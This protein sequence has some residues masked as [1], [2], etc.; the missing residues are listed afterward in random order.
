MCA[1][2]NGNVDDVAVDLNTPRPIVAGGTGATTP[3]AALTALGAVAKAGDTMT[4]NL[5]LQSGGPSLT[6]DTSTGNPNSVLA[7]RTGG[8][9]RWQ[10]FTADTDSPS[11]GSDLFFGA[12]NNAGTLLNGYPLTI[13]RGNGQAAFN[14]QIQA[15]GGIN[16]PVVGAGVK[17]A[18][19][20]RG[21]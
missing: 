14:A 11:S 9:P 13:S 4:G 18:G 3:A 7:L 5:T 8:F 19:W 17:V 15:T 12:Y 1:A 20:R 2:Y 10:I 6:L 21:A 16:C